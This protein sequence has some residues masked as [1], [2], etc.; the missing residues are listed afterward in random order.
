MESEYEKHMDN[1][2]AHARGLV[3]DEAEDIA[4]EAFYEVMDLP[5]LREGEIGGLLMQR[6]KWRAAD[7]LRRREA[8]LEADLGEVDDDGESMRPMQLDD[9]EATQVHHGSVPPW[10]TAIDHDSP[11]EIVTAAQMRDKIAQVCKEHCGA[12]DYGM[13]MAIADGVDQARVAKEWKVDQ[14][15]VSRAVARV[16]NVVSD[17]L[18]ESHP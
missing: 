14:A 11:E 2:V 6:V 5:E 15:T 12:D 4:H 9:L 13:F 3:G 17:F 8:V 1:L 16:R 18:D 10:P 7:F